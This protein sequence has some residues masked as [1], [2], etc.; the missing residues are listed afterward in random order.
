MRH[1]VLSPTRILGQQAVQVPG[2][3]EF[4]LAY[5][6]ILGRSPIY[7]SGWRHLSKWLQEIS[8]VKVDSAVFANQR[9]LFFSDLPYWVD[10]NLA[11][12]VLAIAHGATVDFA[13]FSHPS[14]ASQMPPTIGYP[15]WKRTQKNA[16]EATQH[17]FLRLL[18]LE[19]IPCAKI[20]PRLTEIAARQAVM[21]TSYALLKERVD[22]SLNKTDQREYE[23]RLNR[24]SDAISRIAT[25]CQENKYDRVIIPNGAILEF[26]A[27]YS[28]IADKGI[29]ISTFE[30]QNNG[31]II[32]SHG[33]TVMGMDASDLWA[34][35][36]PHE[37]S[38]ER[39]AR[40]QKF[41][42]S[43]E[44]PAQKGVSLNSFQLAGVVSA[45]DIRKQLGLRP[46][47][48]V[49]L[50][51]PNCA[52]DA[53]Y[54]VEGTRHF[55]TM[56]EWLVKTVS[57]LAKRKDCQVVIRSHPAE[58]YYKAAE[59]TEKLIK[60]FFGKLP[61]HI[62]LVTPED[63]ISTY[64]IMNV[65]D[66]GLI[67]WSTTGMEM[68][69]RGIPVI[70]GVPAVHYSGKGF[71]LDPKTIDEYFALI[72]G[73]IQKPAVSRLTPRQVELSWCYADVF[74]NDWPKPF[75]WSVGRQFWAD[76]KKWPFSRMLSAEGEHKFGGTL[77]A[78]AGK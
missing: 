73:V 54:F 36:D 71:T 62:R 45:T 42:E 7:D 75:P 5:C 19:K 20:T 15:F 37:L 52:F 22:I 2:V 6:K 51:C 8:S 78:L 72:D 50:L 23:F 21:D 65:A 69:M 4:Y 70:C 43:R 61:E 38:A 11:L 58:A 16:E 40:I 63:P 68:S 77:R 67:Y 18:N 9:L 57:Y 66:L 39:S 32:V 64:S 28:F 74:F 24:N 35:D 55:S 13:W 59:T 30:V 47:K 34:K 26:G 29:P 56:T 31:T 49:V 33:A 25:L 41:I 3:M 14:Y 48:P 44:R 12:A 1:K 53:A 17:H 10:Y 46:E 60:E 27:V 76:L